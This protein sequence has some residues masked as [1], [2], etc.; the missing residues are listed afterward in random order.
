[1]NFAI[2]CGGKRLIYANDPESTG[3]AAAP[4]CAYAQGA[5]SLIYAAQSTPAE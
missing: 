3:E 5:H 2:E 4:L 1:M